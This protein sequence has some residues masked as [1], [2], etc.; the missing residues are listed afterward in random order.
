MHPTRISYALVSSANRIPQLCHFIF[1][2]THFKRSEAW[3]DCSSS[4]FLLVSCFPFTVSK[5]LCAIPQFTYNLFR[6]FIIILCLFI[7]LFIYSLTYFCIVLFIRLFVLFLLIKL[8]VYIFLMYLFSLFF[9]L[10]FSRYRF[11]HLKAVD[12]S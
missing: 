2:A 8:F 5:Q 1:S 12:N 7:Y 6:L 11:G 4:Y 3:R 10:F 9:P